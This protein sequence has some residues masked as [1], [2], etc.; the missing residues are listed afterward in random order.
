YYVTGALE[1]V[2]RCP[3]LLDDVARSAKLNR[4]ELAVLVRDRLMQT[5]SMDGFMRLVGVVKE[6]VVC[7]P[8][9]NGRMQL[10]DLN[11]DCW[12]LVRRYLATDDVKCDVAQ[13]YSV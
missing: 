11:E 6:R 9:D 12:S 1:R 8:A 7:H 13:V 10:D 5:K 3:C 2:A 4:A